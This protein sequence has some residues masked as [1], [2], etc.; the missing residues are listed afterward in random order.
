MDLSSEISRCPYLL[1]TFWRWLKAQRSD[2]NRRNAYQNSF[3]P[4]PECNAYQTLEI[5]LIKMKPMLMTKYVRSIYVL[6]M[7]THS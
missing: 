7:V 6:T 2:H 1:W 5:K 3:K 4:S